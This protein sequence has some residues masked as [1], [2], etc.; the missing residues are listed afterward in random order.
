[1][2]S[3]GTVQ[4]VVQAVAAAIARQDGAALA[5]AL[6]LD[7]GNTSLLHQLASG[8]V[9]LEQVRV[10]RRVLI[11]RP[12]GSQTAEAQPCGSGG[13]GSAILWVGGGRSAG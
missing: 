8:R 12:C 3:L 10:C 1:M 2:A 7:M 9:N 11:V 4:A 13:G 6:R 5:A